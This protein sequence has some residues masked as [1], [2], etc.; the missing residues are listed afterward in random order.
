MRLLPESLVAKSA[1]EWPHV[2]VHPHVND[3]V[4]RLAK[5]LAAHLAVLKDPVARLVVAVVKGF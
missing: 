5:R 4:V 1:V 2:L 3:E